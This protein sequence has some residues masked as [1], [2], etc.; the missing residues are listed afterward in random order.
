MRL[1]RLFVLMLAAAVVVSAASMASFACD[2][3]AEGTAKT[4]EAS[5]GCAKAAAK[6][7]KSQPCPH[8]ATAQAKSGEAKGC[9]KPCTGGNAKS[10]EGCAKK[11][12]VAKEKKTDVPKDKESGTAL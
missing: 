5:S 8:A 10:G 4:S 9:D 11:V 7:A 12:D 6:D 2:K 3:A 1:Q